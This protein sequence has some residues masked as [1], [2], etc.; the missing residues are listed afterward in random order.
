MRRAG[1]VRDGHKADS[2]PNT[3]ASSI[4]PSKAG[5]EAGDDG[6]RIITLVSPTESNPSKDRFTM[7]REERE[8]K[9][10]ETRDRIFKGFEDVE[11][12]DAATHNDAGPGVSRTS[13]AN[14]KRK[15]RKQQNIDDGFEARSHFH[16]YY[17]AMQ[18][19][20][21]VLIKH[22]H[23]LHTST[24]V[25]PNSIQYSATQIPLVQHQC[26]QLTTGRATSLCQILQDTPSQC[27]SIPR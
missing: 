3:T 11:N 2:G 19:S 6:G 21:P 18:Y 22:Q 4:A 1:L 20:G 8:A 14:G 17:P 5:S 24:L 13:S 25:C 10:K 26:T 16:A 12:I 23:H 15:S 7:T 27:S 9:Y